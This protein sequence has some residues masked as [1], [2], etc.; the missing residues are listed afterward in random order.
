MEKP[1]LSYRA[2]KIILGMLLG[3]GSLKI[4]DRYTN[5]RLAFRHS[6]VQKEYFLWKV[7]QLKEIS[8]T[9]DMW[10]QPPAL[11]K[12]DMLRYQS[13]ALPVL[14]DLYRLVTENGKLRI[15][16]KWLNKMTALSLA[17]WWMDDGSIVGSGRKGVLCT[18]GFSEKEVEILS[19]YLKVVW[20][21][22]TKIFPCGRPG[23]FRL[24]LMAEELWKFLK[25]I[26][27]HIPVESMLPK[28]C[29]MYSDPNLQ[30]RWISEL[31]S[32]SQF[33]PEAIEK[34]LREKKAKWKKFNADNDIVH[35]Q[36]N[37]GPA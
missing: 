31:N 1:S 9:K 35:L 14:T 26:V 4:H 11:G 37:E 12:N 18:D 21:V 36:T 28:V 22:N 3:D 17:V 30:Q 19:Q 2:E 7:S 34:A 27:P 13:A 29:M 8:S 33:P 16:R 5:A 20:K 32:L 23:Q 25:I 24:S 10:V 6:T 15:R